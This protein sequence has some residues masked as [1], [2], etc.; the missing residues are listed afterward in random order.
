MSLSGHFVERAAAQRS[1]SKNFPLA[2]TKV[3]RGATKDTYSTSF[4][5]GGITF[6][7]AF[8]RRHGERTSR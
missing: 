2:E 3:Q 5:T 6:P 1:S 7:S 4:P 8:A